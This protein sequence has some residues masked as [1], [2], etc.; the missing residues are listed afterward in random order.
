MP[1]NL[2][3]I[4]FAF[5]PF[6]FFLSFFFL[7]ASSLLPHTQILC[8]E[9]CSC[10]SYC[11]QKIPCS[12]L[13]PIH[14]FHHCKHGTCVRAPTRPINR[15]FPPRF[16]RAGLQFK[17]RPLRFIFTTGKQL[18]HYT[19]TLQQQHV[20]W[21]VAAKSY[22]SPARLILCKPFNW[23]LLRREPMSYPRTC[24]STR[25]ISHPS[26]QPRTLGIYRSP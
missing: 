16:V 18:P 20:K 26:V 19:T 25:H 11:S 13:L 8:P 12:H 7:P 6:F 4:F 14:P 15:P 22:S 23:I 3:W 17:L 21:P 9:S 1:F 24:S 2:W 10:T 5:C